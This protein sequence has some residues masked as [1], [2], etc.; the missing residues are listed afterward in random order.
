M[1][2]ERYD[3]AEIGAFLR[4]MVRAMV[5]RA[6]GGDLDVLAVLHFS[7]AAIDLALGDSARALNDQGHS[8]TVIGNELGMTKQAAHQAYARPKVAGE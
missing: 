4:R 2:R 1:A 7:R 6:E 8:W 5:R 3:A